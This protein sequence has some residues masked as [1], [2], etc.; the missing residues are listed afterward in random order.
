M[1]FLELAKKR[2]SVREFTDRPVEKEK[3]YAIL[4][5]ARIAPTAANNQPQRILVI[6]SKEAIEKLDDCTTCR[7]NAPLAF[8]VCYDKTKTWARHYDGHNSGDVDS[9]IVGTHIM[10]EAEDLGLGSVWVMSFDPEKIKQT[11][12]LPEEF[13]PV[14]IFSVGCADE[15]SKPGKMHFDK[16]SL[17][18][19]TF[20]NRF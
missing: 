19:T 14:A 2:Y 16:K 15:K 11:Y 13:E 6:E 12:N 17:E 5:A 18:E 8:L 9:S 1:D 3:I 20:Y 10:M 7:F 4:E